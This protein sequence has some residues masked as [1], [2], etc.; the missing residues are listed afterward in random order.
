MVITIQYDTYLQ[1]LSN[2][3]CFQWGKGDTKATNSYTYPI[4]FTSIYI[5]VGML[6]SSTSSGYFNPNDYPYNVT[7][8]GFSATKTN[9]SHTLYYIAIGSKT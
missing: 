7:V 1:Q 9:S 4:S 8:S 6:S 3:L 2:N 5:L